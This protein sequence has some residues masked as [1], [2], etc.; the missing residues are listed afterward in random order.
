MS[1]TTLITLALLL[2]VAA[3]MCAY[4][5]A[6]NVELWWCIRKLP[7]ARD[8]VALADN[9]D[10]AKPWPTLCLIIPA[11]NEARSIAT[12]A[13]SLLAQDYPHLRVVFVL[14]R[15]T[16]DT[17]QVL[18]QVIGDDDRFT[19]LL[20][21][22]CPPDWA[23][24][25]N[26]VYS[27]VQ[28]TD[29]ART[30]DMLAFADADTELDPRCLRACVA[31]LEHRNL[32]LLSLMSTL[33]CE[34]WFERLIQPAAGYEL[35]RQFPPRRVNRDVSPRPIANGQFMLFMAQ[36][37]HAIGGHNAVHTELLE[38]I[39][40]AKLIART[41]RRGGFLLASGML[42]CHMYDSFRGFVDGWKR[43]YAEM[44]HR[45]PRRLRKYALQLLLTETL[46][47]AGAITA[48]I[49][50]SIHSLD[51]F[52]STAPLPLWHGIVAVICA[53]AGLLGVIA[54]LSA[55]VRGSLWARTPIWVGLL[56]PIGALIV[57]RI[58]WSAARD[59][60]ARVPIR[61]AGKAYIREPRYEGD[62]T[63]RD[64]I[65]GPRG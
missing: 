43:I 19:I 7:T 18:S 24:K 47:P 33:S 64:L 23:G 11:H 2:F 12:V 62:R 57:V 55:L 21:D 53:A 49:L 56:Q 63:L 44:A 10:P 42:V 17:Q 5:I 3:A 54:W 65:L 26:A 4:W 29:E 35:L 30:A 48:A 20:N 51:H 52:A 61:W 38:D 46:L 14:D 8:G 9:R 22:S 40:L 13:R 31:L 58:L 45:R 59:L 32:D 39:A 60:E 36:S 41:G 6:V 16:D 34:R 15:C 37:Y 1:L 25:V 50:G 28:R 27:A